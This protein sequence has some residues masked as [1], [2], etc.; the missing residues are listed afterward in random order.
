MCENVAN[1]SR[2]G[3]LEAMVCSLTLAVIVLIADDTV[4]GSPAMEIISGLG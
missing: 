3:R 2:R 1:G 4:S